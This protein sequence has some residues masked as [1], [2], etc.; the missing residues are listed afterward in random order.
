M[1]VT[2][3][4]VVQVDQKPFKC[5]RCSVRFKSKKNIPRHMET[6]HPEQKLTHLECIVCKKIYQSKGNYDAHYKKKHI[7]EH[8]LYVKPEIV[9]VEG[10]LWFQHQLQLCFI[11]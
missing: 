3:V 6:Q 2:S 4:K 8:L 7:S 9:S 10:K 11:Y 1:K 5:T